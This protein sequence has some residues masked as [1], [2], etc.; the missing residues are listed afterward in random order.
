VTEPLG[1]Q[2]LGIVTKVPTGEVDAANE[3]ITTD[4]V[5]WIDRCS[6]ES[7][8]LSEFQNETIVS[9]ERGYAMMPDVPEVRAI[10]NANHIRNGVGG[11]DFKVHGLPAPETDL[12]GALIGYWLVCEW[13]AG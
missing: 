13:Q 7:E 6:F 5:V 2:K 1:G 4:K 10:T 9:G 11:R 12:D 8:H 3:D